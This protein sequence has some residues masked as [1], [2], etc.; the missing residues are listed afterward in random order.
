V[1]LTLNEERVLAG[2][3]TSLEWADAVLV[4]DS[5]SSD[6]TLEVA[7]AAGARIH[8]RTFDNFSRQRQ[9]ALDLVETEWTLFVDADERVTDALCA[10]VRAAVDSA[11]ANAGYWIPRRNVF[12]GREI[13]GGGWWPDRQLRL[14]RTERARFDL[15]RPVHEVPDLSGSAGEL[16]VPLVHLN[17]D[18]WA[19]FRSKQARYA[20]LEAR[21]RAASGRP[22]RMAGYVTVPV[23]EFWRRFVRLGGWRDGLTGL[24]LALHLAWFEGVTHAETRRLQ[25]APPRRP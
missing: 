7:S 2:C 25:A 16:T 10:E 3:L 13:R 5:A 9:A 1:V 21:R 14:V 8:Q 24:G 15:E 18:S 22:A 20:L 6:A 17:Y 4:V 12:W 23:R 19:E 11:S